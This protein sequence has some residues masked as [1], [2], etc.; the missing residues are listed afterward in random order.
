MTDPTTPI[1]E[2]TAEE[3]EVEA[4]SEIAAEALASANQVW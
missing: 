4:A 1:D 2:L 3:R